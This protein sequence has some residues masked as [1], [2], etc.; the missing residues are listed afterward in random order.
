MSNRWLVLELKFILA[1][2]G[3]KSDSLFI[4]ANKNISMNTSLVPEQHHS[5]EKF[6]FFISKIKWHFYKLGK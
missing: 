6:F 2:D 3:M 4:L 5:R 1:S